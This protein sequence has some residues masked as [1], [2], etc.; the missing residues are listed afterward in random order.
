[1]QSTISCEWV[2]AFRELY[3]KALQK[4][5]EGSRD[6]ARYFAKTET[7]WLASIG[8][9]PMEIYDFAEDYPEIDCEAALLI[10][11]VR[12]DYFLHVMKGRSSGRRIEPDNLPARDAKLA[13]IPWLPR[14]IFKAKAKL[15]GEMPDSLMYGCGGDRGFLKQFDIHPADFLRIVWAAGENDSEIVRFVKKRS[16][17]DTAPSK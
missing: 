3:G 17:R 9:S 5:G 16:V 12:R 1:M 6:A 4:Y 13:G 11:E 10:S 14:I 2:S 15:R 7:A 8:C